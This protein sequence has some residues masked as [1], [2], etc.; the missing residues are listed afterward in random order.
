MNEAC[1][2]GPQHPKDQ[3]CHR[4]EVLARA[5]EALVL[6]DAA[7]AGDGEDFDGSSDAEVRGNAGV[8]GCRRVGPGS[9]R[10]GRACGTYT[11][12]PRSAAGAR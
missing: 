7:T 9:P 4:G 10:H 12:I 8:R 11:H 6:I 2:R 5:D 3:H 1:G